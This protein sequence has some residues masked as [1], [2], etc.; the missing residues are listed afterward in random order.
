MDRAYDW[1]ATLQD[2]DPL[3][4]P[5]VFAAGYGLTAREGAAPNA[6]NTVRYHTEVT[7]E[8]LKQGA[9][10][11][12]AKN[13]GACSGDSGGPLIFPQSESGDLL[14]G[15]ALSTGSTCAQGLSIYNTYALSFPHLCWMK[16]IVNQNPNTVDFASHIRCDET[17]VVETLDAK[18]VCPELTATGD[19]QTLV[20]AVAGAIHTTECATI[21]KALQQGRNLRL[22][23]LQVRDTSFLAGGFFNE[24]DLSFNKIDDLSQWTSISVLTEL[25][26]AHNRLTDIGGIARFDVLRSLIFDH[27]RVKEL[28]ANE[29]KELNTLRF[30]NNEVSRIPD[31]TASPKLRTIKGG[32]NRIASVGA[33]PSGLTEVFLE[34]NLLTDASFEQDSRGWKSFFFIRID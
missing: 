20:D 27:N 26:L 23:G 33:L 24:L 9:A 11:T 4:K 3:K 5:S 19:G 10:R 28:P 8:K 13:T 21:K 14:L 31:L 12:V 30:W 15:G 6:L 29:W 16:G 1:G 17:G 34:Q 7:I 2:F 32:R 25:N 18:A 22:S